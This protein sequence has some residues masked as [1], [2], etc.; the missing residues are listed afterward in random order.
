[1]GIGTPKTEGTYTRQQMILRSKIIRPK[2]QF[3][4]NSERPGPYV[5]RRI[6][7]LDI[8]MGWDLP[9][10]QSQYRLDHPGNPCCGLQ[11]PDIGLDRTDMTNLPR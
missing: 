2:C 8:Q 5:Q 3:R 11:V 9:V 1:M 6:G 10:L 4:G 7:G